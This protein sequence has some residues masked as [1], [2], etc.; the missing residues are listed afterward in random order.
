MGATYLLTQDNTSKRLDA[1]PVHFISVPTSRKIT[2]DDL[3]KN[4]EEKS[5]SAPVGHNDNQTCSDGV[6]IHASA[7][8]DLPSATA[9]S[10]SSSFTVPHSPEITEDDDMV[11]ELLVNLDKLTPPAV[12]HPK[13]KR[14]SV[15][16]PRSAPM[17][18]RA[19]PNTDIVR[20]VLY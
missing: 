2:S 20:V 6:T 3:I 8:P 5:P 1:S 15:S 14:S 10:V 18:K 4:T 12:A 9:F 7:T 13:A 17:P 16:Q 19:K 11:L